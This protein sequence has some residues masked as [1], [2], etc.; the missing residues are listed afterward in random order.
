[1][2]VQTESWFSVVNSLRELPHMLDLY[3]PKMILITSFEKDVNFPDTLL[4]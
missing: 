1:M 4:K 2:D 3:V